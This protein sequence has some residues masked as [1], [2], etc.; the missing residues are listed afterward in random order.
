M[1]AGTDPVAVDTLGAAV[2]GIP[3]E[4]I[5]HSRLADERGLETCDLKQIEVLG[6]PMDRVKKNFRAPLASGFFSA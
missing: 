1:I 3:P 2:M 5:K 4:G 6:E